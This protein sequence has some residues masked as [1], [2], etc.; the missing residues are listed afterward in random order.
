[1]PQNIKGYTPRDYE[2]FPEFCAFQEFSGTIYPRKDWRELIELQKEN[3]SSPFHVHKNN[4]IQVLNQRSTPYCWM[5]GTVACVLNRAAAQGIQPVP[6]LNAQATAAMGKR[7]RKNGGF[8]IE[9][10][11]YIEKYGIPTCDVWP[12]HNFNKSYE[13]KPEVKES[14]KLHKIVTF[15]E[16]PRNN[17]DAVMS[18]LL[19]P[20]DP[21][22]V[23]LA[24]NWWRH[25]VCGL[26]GVYNGREFGLGFV[27]SWGTKYKDGGFSEVF[28]SRAVPFEAVAVR[29]IKSI[30]E[31]KS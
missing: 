9:A 4:N 21:V 19:C 30:T 2:Q 1:M 8:G 10:C 20:V 7:Y 3:E 29:S 16:L 24:F 11:K 13:G 5:Y 22:P 23:T 26:R 14:A 18:A 27:N 25:L 28:G 6:D 17:F 12:E 31:E 15:E